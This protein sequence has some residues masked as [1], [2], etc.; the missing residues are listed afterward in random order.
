VFDL[1]VAVA[2][3]HLLVRKERN[4]HN[5]SGP[6]R[7][8]KN[9]RTAEGRQVYPACVRCRRLNVNNSNAGG[10]GG[11]ARVV[12]RETERA[13]GTYAAR[14]QSQSQLRERY[15]RRESRLSSKN[16]E[17]SV[18]ENGEGKEEVKIDKNGEGPLYAQDARR[19]IFQDKKPAIVPLAV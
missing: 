11:A 13:N 3:S 2:R 18:R 6:R 16:A 5:I 14:M 9:R 17:S 8:W 12:K 19:F 4:F 7:I 10:I 15:L 1:R